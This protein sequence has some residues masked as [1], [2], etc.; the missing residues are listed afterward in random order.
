MSHEHTSNISRWDELENIRKKIEGSFKNIKVIKCSAEF[1]FR[2]MNTDQLK[3]YLK[4]HDQYYYK[5]YQDNFATE[6]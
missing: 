6:E 3:D 4:S 1:N 5:W 2:I